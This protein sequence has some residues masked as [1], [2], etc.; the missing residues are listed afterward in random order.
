MHYPVV[1]FSPIIVLTILLFY[2][3][4]W[5]YLLNMFVHLLPMLLVHE[6][7]I[8]SAL[9]T[10]FLA[11]SWLNKWENKQ[12][13]LNNKKWQP[14]EKSNLMYFTTWRLNSTSNHLTMLI[15][16]M[17]KKARLVGENSINRGKELKGG[18]NEQDC[19]EHS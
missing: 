14:T 5:N 18:G 16:K 6:P 10:S 17:Y 19:F 8:I 13:Q 9:I 7:G 2:T 15:W 3:F 12:K 11:H 4:F 1:F